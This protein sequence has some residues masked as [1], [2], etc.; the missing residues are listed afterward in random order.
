MNLYKVDY[1]IKSIYLSNQR[2][3]LNFAD[4]GKESLEYGREYTI[5]ILPEKYI[6][7]DEFGDSC[8]IQSYIM[9]SHDFADKIIRQVETIQMGMRCRY[10]FLENL[11][12][13]TGGN[14]ND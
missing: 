3:I 13:H 11:G 12:R 7:E 2:G 8:N 9:R 10:Y 4:L 6:M 14:Y 5:T 1:K